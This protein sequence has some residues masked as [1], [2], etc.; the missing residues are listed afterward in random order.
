M[1]RKK[2]VG[3][4]EGYGAMHQMLVKQQFEEERMIELK[5]ERSQKER[6]LEMP[7]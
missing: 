4:E 3:G 7:S 1:S 5:A 6:A 2:C